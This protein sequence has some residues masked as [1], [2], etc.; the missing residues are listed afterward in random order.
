MG[1]RVAGEDTFFLGFASPES[2]LAVQPGVRPAGV[3]GRTLGT[4]FACYCLA[5]QP[6]L[7]PFGLRGKK[8]MRLASTL[9]IRHPNLLGPAGQRQIDGHGHGTFRGCGLGKSWLQPDCS[10]RFGRRN[11]TNDQTFALPS[12]CT[13][14]H[15]PVIEQTDSGRR[16]ISSERSACRRRGGSCR[17]RAA[18]H[19]QPS[20]R[21]SRSPT[22]SA[23]P[24][25]TGR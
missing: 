4:Q 22:S 25:P 14:V 3:C 18:G 13:I 7:R 24:A 23:R 11:E 16:S 15:L 5:A 9:G 20:R 12:L 17:H 6:G 2:V 19:R 8:D 1:R 10:S 21:S